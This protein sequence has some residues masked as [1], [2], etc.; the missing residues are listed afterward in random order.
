MRRS[1]PV[2]S[3]AFSGDGTALLSATRTG[4]MIWDVAGA[5]A[6]HAV[7]VPGGV[8]RAALSPD[9]SL[10]ATAG[11]DDR[12]R[13]YDA[14][15]GALLHILPGH[16]AP[17]TDVFFAD[18]RSLV[19]TSVDARPR[20][21]NAQTGALEHVLVGHFG[22]VSTAAV[23]PDGRWIAT[24]GPL[25]AGLWPT[26]AARLLF[27]LRGPTALLT[28]I[29]FTADGR[30]ILTSSMDGTVRIYTCEVCV[31]LGGLVALARARLERTARDLTPA[32][33][34]RYL[35]P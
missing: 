21:W 33:R 15:T 23:S 34:A 1:G 20:V 13:I 6:L 5:R 7:D 19:T 3:L 31:D 8:V 24:A 17:L 26:A 12:A 29:S 16:T 27:Y 22:T 14:H 28:S 10:V 9:A 2:V 35:S 25:S 4:L 18:G 11:A 30:R 32:Q